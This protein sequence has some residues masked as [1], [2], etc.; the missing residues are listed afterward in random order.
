LRLLLLLG[1]PPRCPR[2][3]FAR[4]AEKNPVAGLASQWCQLGSE[5]RWAC[6]TLAGR[7]FEHGRC[8]C[9]SERNVSADTSFRQA[10][11]V[12]HRQA[13]PLFVEAFPVSADG[14]FGQVATLFGSCDFAAERSFLTSLAG[15]R[16]VA[17]A[18][19]KYG[20]LSVFGPRGCV[21]AGQ[22]PVADVGHG[23]LH[24]LDHVDRSMNI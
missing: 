19:L 2:V 8:A 7:Y 10:R 11:H 13:I 15:E 18:Q 16:R 4:L 12:R 6:A 1:V 9:F 24:W 23:W 21:I 5:G 3:A 17:F 14:A 20:M 22:G